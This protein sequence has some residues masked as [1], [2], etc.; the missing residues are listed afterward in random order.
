M[1]QKGLVRWFDKNSGEGMI[2][3]DDGKSHWVYACNIL[4]AKT[5]FEHTA[6]VYLVQGEAVEFE[7]H[8]GCGAVKV[9]GGHFDAEKWASLDQDRLAFKVAENGEI[10][11]GLFSTERISK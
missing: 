2:R 3:G 1:R 5:L 8:D 11:N 6:C 7:L 9:S 4:G 10:E